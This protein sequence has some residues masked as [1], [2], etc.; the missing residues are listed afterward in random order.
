MRKSL[1][2][3]FSAT[4][5]LAG[6]FGGGYLLGQQNSDVASAQDLKQSAELKTAY[7]ALHSALKKQDDGYMLNNVSRADS[8]EQT[9]REW[10]EYITDKCQNEGL[11]LAYGGTMSGEITQTC[12]EESTKNRTT[13]LNNLLQ[14]SK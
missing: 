7:D 4:V 12:L 3:I 10:R 9:Q 8:L 13:E 2:T 14:L 1:I 6:F 11:V 5:M